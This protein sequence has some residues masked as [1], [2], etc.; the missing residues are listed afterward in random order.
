MAAK[1]SEKKIIMAA[2]ISEKKFIITA[3]ERDRCILSFDEF[4][5]RA[6]VLT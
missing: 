3:V 4:S 5:V 2:K 6:G 1:I